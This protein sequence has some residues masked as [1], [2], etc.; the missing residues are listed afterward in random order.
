MKIAPVDVWRQSQKCFF[1]RNSYYISPQ[2][3]NFHCTNMSIFLIHFASILAKAIQQLQTQP[4]ETIKTAA[5]LLGLK[6]EAS[7]EV[8][9]HVTPVFAKGRPTSLAL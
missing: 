4:V 8:Q 7:V 9:G 3:G 5:Q 6:C 1:L 2:K